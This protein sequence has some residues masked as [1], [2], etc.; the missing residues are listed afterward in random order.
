[1]YFNRLCASRVRKCVCVVTAAHL[2]AVLSK[3]V[4]HVVQESVADATLTF[5]DDV[6]GWTWTQQVRALACCGVCV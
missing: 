3:H 2:V 1:M 6:K 5:Q 4:A